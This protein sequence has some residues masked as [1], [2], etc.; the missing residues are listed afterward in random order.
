MLHSLLK[1]HFG[2]DQFRPLQEEVISEVMDGRD[3]VVLMPTG[4]GKSLCYQIPALMLPGITLVISPLIA[5]MKDQVDGL[6]ANG[7]AAASIHSGI[8]GPEIA[9]IQRQATAGTIKLL[10]ISPERLALASF[11]NFLS[12]LTVSLLA[13]D[14]AH[15]ISEWGHDFRPDYR[16]LKTLREKFTRVPVIALTATATEKVREDII[17]QLGLSKAHVFLSSFNRPNLT[18]TVKPKENSLN[19]I[20]NALAECVGESAIIYCFSRKDVEVLSLSLNK[21][22]IKALPYH[23][24]LSTEIRQKNQEQFIRDE[25]DV[26]VATIAFGMGI[27]KPDVRLV[28]HTDLPKSLEGYY[29]ETGRA[30]RDGLPS[31]CVLLYSWG[32]SSKQEFFISQLTDETEQARS[33]EKLRQILEYCQIRGCRR[34]HLMHYFGEEWPEEG[35]GGCDNCLDPQELFDATEIAKKVLSAVLRTGERFG[36]GMVAGVLLG[37][38]TVRAKQPWTEQLSVWGIVQNF[39]EDDLKQIMRLLAEAGLLARS[40]GEYPTLAVSSEG[41]RFLKGVIPLELP[42]PRPAAGR[43]KKDK[44]PRVIAGEGEY[45]RDLFE[46]LRILRKSLADDLGVPPFIVFGDATLRQ[47]SSMKPQTLEEFAQIS[48][49]GEKKLDQFGEVFLKTIVS[50]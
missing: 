31:R 37:S 22:G 32:D 24:G 5:L 10:Y 21:E 6:Q 17:S 33:R 18:Y 30:G 8:S 44:T 28:V 40:D 47:M 27:D 20:K 14:E 13:I 29:Q 9:D 50:G 34:A 3:A 49:V 45:D 7:V 46:Q 23:A 26:M 25:V 42:R 11:Q 15:C 4:G 43:K 2:Y 19:L 39:S 48:G 41:K 36:A 35:C 16:N 1:T 12:T 38:S